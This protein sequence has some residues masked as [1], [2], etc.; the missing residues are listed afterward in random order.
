M[1][2]KPVVLIP[3]NRHEIQDAPAHVVKHQYIRPLVEV[4]DCIP[5]LI[6]AI[7][8]DFNIHDLA[9]KID[10][11]LLTG[12]PSHVSPACYGA[13]REFEDSYLDTHRDDMTIPMIKEALDMDLPIFAICRGFQELNITLGGTLHQYVH[14]LDD[15]L[16]HR[17]HPDI[18][19]KDVFTYM[20]H[21]VTIEDGGMFEKISLP[22]TFKVNTIHTQG[23]DK[24]GNGLRI[25]A[26]A[27]DGLI[28]G[29]SLPD[30]KFVIGT[31]WH[32]EGDFWQNPPDK[33]LFESFGNALRSNPL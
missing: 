31:Q 21:D 33:K 24:L 10:G 14:K 13:E 20:S 2:H 28:E 32:P 30:K 23:I 1:A 17:A 15:K 27:E 18:P 4:S 6:P 19:F 11:I 3:C 26:R 5:L 8:T 22:K 29:I 9:G 25:E 12:S 7:G 16:N